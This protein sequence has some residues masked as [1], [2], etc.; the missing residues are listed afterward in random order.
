M[1]VRVPN[2]VG[3]SAAIAIAVMRATGLTSQVVSIASATVPAGVIISMT[4]VAGSKVE[5][6]SVVKLTKSS[7]PAE[8]IIHSGVIKVPRAP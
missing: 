6:G 8:Q 1:S 4:P 7:G 2:V 5:Q 3:E